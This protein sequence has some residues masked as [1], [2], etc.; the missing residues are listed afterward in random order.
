MEPEVAIWRE[1]LKKRGMRK[2]PE[3]EAI[4]KEVLSFGEHF[5]VDSLWLRLKKKSGVSKASIY[6]TIPLLIDVGLIT[7]VYLENGHMHYEYV[8]GREHHCHLRCTNCKKTIEF[9][10]D[11]LTAIEHE[12]GAKHGFVTNGLKVEI[13][14]LC[15]KCNRLK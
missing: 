15:P 14:G 10:D 7:E 1:Y 5:D 13:L 3:R 8:Y 6:R 4:V 11:R 12:L 2:T 9:S